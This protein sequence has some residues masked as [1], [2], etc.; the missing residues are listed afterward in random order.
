LIQPN[1]DLRREL[2]TQGALERLVADLQQDATAAVGEVKVLAGIEAARMRIAF[3]QKVASGLVLALVLIACGVTAALAGVRL[4]NGLA[5][6]IAQAA[7]AR[8]LGDVV[9]GAVVLAVFGL[10]G[11]LL[12]RQRDAKRLA[13][14]ER[15]FAE[16]KA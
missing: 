5:E 6:G 7:G 14:L 13:E 10:G 11:L 1:E 3:E 9:S 2:G 12:W 15:E 16:P 8:W 4:L